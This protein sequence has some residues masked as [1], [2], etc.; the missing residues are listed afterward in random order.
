MASIGEQLR[1]AREAQGL[2]VSDIEK[3][4]HIRHTFVE[5]LEEDRFQDLPDPA[6][7][8]GFIRNYARVVGLDP[9]PLVASFAQTAGSRSLQV[10]EMLDEPLVGHTHHGAR[11]AVIGIVIGLLIIAVAW[12]A[13]NYYY[14]HRAPWSVDWPGVSRDV[15]A[16]A[17]PTTVP[18][19]ASPT[20]T[21][22]PTATPAPLTPTV[23]P[24][25][26]SAPTGTPE[27]TGFATFVTTSA[28][29]TPA[30]TPPAASTTSTVPPSEGLPVAEGLTVKLTASD[31][32]WLSVTVD[33]EKA[34]VGY[35]NAGEERS[36]VGQQ[37][38]ELIIGN[39]AAIGIEVNGQ[40]V[41]PLGG[42]GQVA[43]VRYTPET[44]RR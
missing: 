4:T 28:S 24:A 34:F 9:E 19:V 39:A 20:K 31:Y 14:L 5:A 30:L 26:S 11:S 12:G 15:S 23:A 37:A 3:A 21:P 40:A 38:I 41:S 42:K 22:L 25:H 36:F 32:T 10:P 44:L 27:P 18:S 8:R 43:T 2:S 33:E 16:S 35:M 1:Q 17:T 29:S 6:Y 7:V 13:Y